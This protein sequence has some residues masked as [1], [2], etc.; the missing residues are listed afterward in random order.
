MKLTKIEQIENRN[1]Y[2]PPPEPPPG[3]VITILGK[4]FCDKC[5]SSR[6]IKF[7]LSFPFLFRSCD[8]PLCKGE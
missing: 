8:Q 3:R 1:N 4:V 7:K 6:S 5:G 2:P